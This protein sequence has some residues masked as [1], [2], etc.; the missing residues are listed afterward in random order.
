MSVVAEMTEHVICD[1]L[2][3]DPT[4]V[5]DEIAELETLKSAVEARQARLAVTLDRIRQQEA[6]C[7]SGDD[8]ERRPA[9][10]A[11]IA[12]ARRV[13][14]HQG[15]RFLSLAR[16]LDRSLPA[17][18]AAFDAG[19]ISEWRVGIIARDSSPPR[20]TGSSH[21]SRESM[22][23]FWILPRSRRDAG[24]RSPHAGSASARSRTPWSI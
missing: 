19:V 21:H 1:A 17:T 18:A 4:G 20:G 3:H 15:R 6:P 12:L 16:H 8:P 9:V 2:P 22:R 24:R 14:P 5:A 7:G 10:H 11:E 23:R 13:S